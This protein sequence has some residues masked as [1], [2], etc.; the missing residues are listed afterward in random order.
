[1]ACFSTSNDLGQSLRVHIPLSQDK[2]FEVEIVSVAF[3]FLIGH[4]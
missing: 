4:K 1:M 2:S 3:G